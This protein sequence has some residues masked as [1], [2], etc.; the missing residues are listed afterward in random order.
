MLEAGRAE[1]AR[2]AEQSRR[3]RERARAAQ[4]ESKAP[5]AGQAPDPAALPLE[6]APGEDLNAFRESDRYRLAFKALQD[7]PELFAAWQD[8]L[9]ARHLGRRPE[10]V[11]PG[12]GREPRDRD[13]AARDLLIPIGY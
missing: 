3:D 4:E 7:H 13:E 8:A 10:T 11:R 9:L 5:A 2:R 1:K 6:P 12:P